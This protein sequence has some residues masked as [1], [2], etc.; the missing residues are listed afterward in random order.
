MPLISIVIT[1]YASLSFFPGS[2]LA[3]EKARLACFEELMRGGVVANLRLESNI[4]VFCFS[5]TYSLLL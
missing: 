3:R 4:T 1:D 5:L 2:S